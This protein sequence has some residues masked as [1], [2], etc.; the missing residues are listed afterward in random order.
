[1]ELELISKE[2]NSLEFYIK[3]ERHTL[4]ALLKNK[5][6]SNKH[7]DFVAYKLDHPLD[8]RARFFIRTNGKDPKEIIAQACDEIIEEANNFQ[9]SLKKL[10]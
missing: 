5:L 8:N 1:M 4:P 10:K 6:E 9:N 3:G 7:V 2:K